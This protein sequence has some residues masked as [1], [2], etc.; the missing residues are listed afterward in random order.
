MAGFE[1][2]L[3]QIALSQGVQKQVAAT[4]P[5]AGLQDVFGGTSQLIGQ[6]AANPQYGKSAI[7]YGLA[8]G[9]L[10]GILGGLGQ[11]YTSNQSNLYMGGLGQIMGGQPLTQPEG[12]DEQLFG[13]LQGLGSLYAGAQAGRQKEAQSAFSSDILKAGLTEKA[14]KLGELGAYNMPAMQGAS[15]LSPVSKELDRIETEARSAL[16]TAK[17]VVDFGDLQSSFN[18]MLDTY[19]FNDRA[20]TKTFIASFARVNDPG[21]TVKEGEIKSAENTASLLESLGYNLKSLFDGTQTLSPD[22]K[23]EILRAAG[24]KYNTFGSNVEHYVNAQKDLVSRL[25][26][27]PDNVF[28]PVEYKPFDFVSWAKGAPAPITIEQQKAQAAA[29]I[30]ALGQTKAPSNPIEVMATLQQISSKLDNPNLPPDQRQALVDQANQLGS[31]H[32]PVTAGRAGA[33]RG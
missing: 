33:P 25:G 27:R 8:S 3:N 6:A 13:Q 30:T 19:G 20:A 22:T 24:A 26:A 5:Y 23:Q 2:L 11:D 18:T 10:E 9:L 29:G 12:L 31:S 21:S 1:D 17:P 4:N 16:K 7:G 14:K 28:S 15:A 32:L